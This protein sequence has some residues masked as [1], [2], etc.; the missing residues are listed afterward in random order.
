[1]QYEYDEETQRLRINVLGSIYGPS[2]ED[3]DVWMAAV[4]DKLLEIKKI[5]RVVLAERREYEYDFAEVKMLYEIAN[6]I[7]RI[8]RERIISL[9][10]IV[11]DKCDSDAP[12]RYKELQAL[13][14]N[15]KYDPIEAYKQLLREI[16][17]TRARAE[18]EQDIVKKECC[19]HYLNNTL[20]PLQHILENCR[21]IQLAKEHLEEHL[22]RALYRRIFHP[23]I[24][25]NFMYTRYIAAPPRNAEL[26]ERYK[27]GETDVGIYQLPGKVRKLYHVIP[28]EF[29]LSEDEYTLLDLGRR[30]IGR[31]EP[32]E[33]E[34]EKP[35]R[36]RENL[37]RISVD[38]L[39]D[40]ARTNKIN[41]TEMQLAKLAD[42]LT[43]Y[44]AG[45]GI[46]ELL[47]TDEN[48]QDIAV[49]SP[50]GSSPIYLFHGIYQE[51]ETNIVPSSED[52]DAWA[53]RFRL[54]SGRPL[55]EANPV[56]DT[57]ITVPG[58]RARIAAITRS[59]SPE[60]LAFAFR[61]HREKP[62]T[63][64]L[65]IKNKMI[66]PF[67]AALMW[68]LIDGSRTMLI[69]GTR[70]SGK[71]SFLGACMVQI[72]PK[73]RIITV[74]DSVTGDCQVVY[75]RNG[76][77]EKGTVGKL[78][79]DTIE[80]YGCEYDFGREVTRKNPEDVRVFSIGK[81]GK[82]RLSKV[83]TFIRHMTTKDIYEI[84]TRTGKKI[85]VT[86]DHSL[87]TLGKD[88]EIKQAKVRELKI[89]D[90]LVTPRILPFESESKES[91]DIFECLDKIEKGYFTGDGIKQCIEDNW[92]EIKERIKNISKKSFWKRKKILP[93]AFVKDFSKRYNFDTNIYYK[94]AGN[95]KPI[96]R[97]IPL[98]NEIM[99]FFGFWLADGCYDKKSVIISVVD[100]ES[101]NCV[102]KAAEFFGA[103]VKMHSDGFSLMLNSSTLKY[104]ME[105]LGFTGHAYTKKIPSWIYGLD[106]NK[107]ASLL[108]GLFSGDGYLATSEAAINL[109]SSELIKDVQTLLLAFGIIS[110]VNRL[111]K[112]KTYSC[113]ISAL[114]SLR[115][116]QSV[117]FI[118]SE[119]M[120]K[121]A[122]IC[123]KKSFH[124]T[125][126]VIPLPQ[127]FKRIIH[128]NSGDFNYWDYIARGNNIGRQKLLTI[129]KHV[130]NNEIAS[131]L[132]LLAESNIFWDQI[133]EIRRMENEE[134]RVYDFSV[135]EHE[136]F[137]CEN[138]LAHNT[139]EL[140]VEQLRDLSYNIERLKSRSVITHVETELPAEEALR[141]ALR[142]G[143][144]SLIVGEV[145]SKE[146]LAL[147]E[148]M[149]IG[150][151]SN[152][153]AGTIHGESAYGVFDR[154][155]NDLGVPRT[156]F[157]ATD[158]IIIA[159]MLRSPDGLRAFRRVV[160]MTE[161]RKHWQRDPMN[162]RGFVN[163]LEYSAKDDVLK[164]T[165]TL[166]MGE[167]QVLNDIASRVRDWKGSWENVW[168]NINLRAKI[169][170]TLTSYGEK[171]PQLLEAP[172]VIESNSIFHLISSAV[173]EELG[174]LEP[175]VIYERWHE[176][177]KSKAS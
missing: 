9:K 3:Y 155:V 66:D 13:F 161:V 91:I 78:I 67:S 14:V 167:S 84:T 100:E 65:F 71:S 118:Q 55:D 156:S 158:V 95:S 105:I 59:L 56:L 20:L 153:V 49:N 168:S 165:K 31:H 27:I 130:T 29:R 46:L 104:V 144:S 176:W 145:R 143:D 148:A 112:D 154:V 126:D 68:F 172:T 76:K 83:S 110:R 74:E 87:F 57:D 12:A 171:K 73:I 133:R 24:R 51:C 62:W 92:K 139:L 36:V 98:T 64:P 48:I 173:K 127:E 89:D 58:G 39:Q 69:A 177:M 37:M 109:V 128:K 77:I 94:S 166:L 50:A 108:R 30:Y 162:E 113:R 141:T 25:P 44:T 15:L 21:M 97:L 115:A 131:K 26:I 170:E 54:Q 96:P 8:A 53:T 60:G 6:A 32:H 40:L 75:K 2:L 124:D 146:A 34:L 122:K 4:I 123:S 17:H 70:S 28:P 5:V 42:I 142:L 35:E 80:K 149:R 7:E 1:M 18:R 150:A 163:L 157:K 116:F 43:R 175:S 159:N 45:L 147:Y 169:L 63:F 33:T 10:N 134:Q 79:D 85:K 174:N 140:P 16:R 61:R 117:G 38:L 82:I 99:E 136:N 88:S 86:G 101:R 102:K 132:L 111:K 107:R 135:P 90:Y 129:T 72:M 151:L 121:L 52:A 23:S 137:I 106:N 19:I 103:N 47:L 138:I 120:K 152:V 160:E 22:N 119:R 114:S 41:I 11:T 164:P 93:V 125:S 81:D